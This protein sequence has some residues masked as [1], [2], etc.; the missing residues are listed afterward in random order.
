[1]RRTWLAAG[2]VALCARP[3]AAQAPPPAPVKPT[4]SVV[5][6][7]AP[8]DILKIRMKAS[9]TGPVRERVPNGSILKNFGC[10]DV[11]GYSWCQVEAV[12]NPEAH[13]WTPARYLR[14]AESGE[15]ALVDLSMAVNAEADVATAPE[16]APAATTV[17]PDAAGVVSVAVAAAQIPMPTLAPVAIPFAAAPETTVVAPAPS[18]APAE[19]PPVET[20]A[21]TVAAP[22]AASDPAESA[23]ASPPPAAAAEAAPPA[24]PRRRAMSEWDRVAFAARALLVGEPDEPVA[25][26]AA[27]EP[28]PPAPVAAASDPAPAAASAPA[29]AQPTSD[30]RRDRPVP[31][32]I[33]L[34]ARL[35]ADAGASPALEAQ[36]KSAE[37]IGRT[38]AEDA[39]ALAFA[40]MDDPLP[41]AEPEA[42][43]LEA[44]DETFAAPDVAPVPSARPASPDAPSLDP[45]AVGQTS[46]LDPSTVS[47]PA[48]EAV[49][50]DISCA[51]YIGQPMTRCAAAVARMAEDAA[52]VTV[53]W[54]D[55]GA[56]LLRFRSGKP[57]S[58]NARG[59]LRATR[60]GDLNMI[61]VGASERFEILDALVFGG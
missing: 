36:R 23:A 46:A 3:L 49:A 13:G 35:D 5:T 37:T 40:A 61:R 43:A 4:V 21:A 51:R 20:P 8:D 12:G 59:A 50:V 16:P 55:G 58:S 29:E 10:S 45:L 34:S 30:G 18:I 32:R 57:E 26:D 2:L 56:R 42:S 28:T 31:A 41:A 44:P 39:Y 54:P 19:A 11:N 15:A 17:A 38:A 25:D 60:E 1:M 27:A 6:G 48:A 9:P 52:D 14:A 24:A 22:P 53:T 7:V 47:L 33:D